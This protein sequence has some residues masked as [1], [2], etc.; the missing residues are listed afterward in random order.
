MNSPGGNFVKSAVWHTIQIKISA[1]YF[2][3]QKLNAVCDTLVENPKLNPNNN[4][5]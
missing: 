5:N 3:G 4:Y 1:F 2:L